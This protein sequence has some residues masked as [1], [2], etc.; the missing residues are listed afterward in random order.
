MAPQQT[1]PTDREIRT[2]GGLVAGLIAGAW[3]AAGVVGGFVNPDVQRTLL[4][5]LVPPVFIVILLGRRLG[6]KALT[7]E[8][9][10]G[11]PAVIQ[12]AMLTVAINSFAVAFEALA[13]NLLTTP[14]W[15]TYRPTI[16]EL[17]LGFVVGPIILG[18]LGIVT[19]GL[20]AIWPALASAGLWSY[21]LRRSF[22]RPSGR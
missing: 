1:G 11:L 6:V 14:Y 10:I 16:G 8:F 5:L 4:G 21:L 15:D 3:L 17:V 18:L 19:F 7:S 22:G 20:I 12:M 9:R 13:W 2:R